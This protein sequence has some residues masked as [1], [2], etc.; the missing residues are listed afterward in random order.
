MTSTKTAC[1]TTPPLT[2]LLVLLLIAGCATTPEPPP[3]P[4][5]PVVEA[6]APEPEAPPPPRTEPVPPPVVIKNDRKGKLTRPEKAVW[7]EQELAAGIASY[8]DGAYKLAERQLQ[9]ALALG[10]DT[11]SKRVSAHK[12]LAFI[13]CVAGNEAQCRNEF[14][15]AL[16][17]DARFALSPAEAGH[18]IWGPVFR[19]LK[20]APRRPAR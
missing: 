17:L 2:R 20:E 18:P 16:A 6:P 10:L 7:A 4:P 11:R 5:T 15:K 12:Y 3:A 19:G 8:E 1:P 14:R 13:Q 9:T